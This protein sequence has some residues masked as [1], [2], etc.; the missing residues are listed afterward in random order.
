[1]IVD[2]EQDVL[3]LLDHIQDRKTLLVP[4]FSSPTIHVS[5]NPLVAL[6]IYCETGDECIVPIRHTE[7]LR[8]FLELVPRF[9]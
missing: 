3:N 8:G 1:M 5:C 4:I 7:Q 6:Y 9:L 2:H